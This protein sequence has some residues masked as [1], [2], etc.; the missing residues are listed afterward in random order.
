[1]GAEEEI[2]EN[3][4][5]EQL[6]SDVA[7]GDPAKKKKKVSRGGRGGGRVGRRALEMGW[8]GR[9]VICRGQDAA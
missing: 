2:D 8:G 5:I 7:G 6:D 9:L 4:P 1:M 3:E